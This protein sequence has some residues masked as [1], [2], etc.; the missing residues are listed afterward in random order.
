MPTPSSPAPSSPMSFRLQMPSFATAAPPLSSR[1]RSLK[2]FPMRFET[3]RVRVRI[4]V[5][6]RVRVGHRIGLRSSF[7]LVSSCLVL[8]LSCFGFVLSW[9]FFVL[10][11]FCLGRVLAWSAFVLVSS[12]SCLGLAFFSVLFYLGLILA[13][14]VFVWSGFVMV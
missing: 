5:R 12:W 7:V 8:V 9:S 2:G 1:Q 13:W 14:S 11:L 3:V 4:R 10:V 6:C